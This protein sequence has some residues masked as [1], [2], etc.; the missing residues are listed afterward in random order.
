M[1]WGWD[2][3]WERRKKCEVQEVWGFFRAKSIA[4]PFQHRFPSRDWQAEFTSHPWPG[5]SPGLA[6]RIRNPFNIILCFVIGFYGYEPCQMSSV[7]LMGTEEFLGWLTD[8]GKMSRAD[9][10]SSASKNK[11]MQSPWKQKQLMDL[12]W[13]DSVWA[14]PR[15]RGRE[16]ERH[17]LGVGQLRG[18]S[19]SDS[20][21]FIFPRGILGLLY[22]MC[23]SHAPWDSWSCHESVSAEFLRHQGGTQFPRW[24]PIHRN[25][26]NAMDREPQNA[27]ASRLDEGKRLP[28]QRV[29]FWQFFTMQHLFFPPSKCI[30]P[31]LPSIHFPLFPPMLWEGCGFICPVHCFV[32]PDKSQGRFTFSFPGPQCLFACWFV[33]LSISN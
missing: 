1:S 8:R 6:P 24:C 7:S 22:P 19:Q 3:S 13:S 26:G 11:T 21:A 29:I 20:P 27:S 33:L 15:E 14:E 23:P 9:G 12:E 5:L 32:K 31:F 16:G 17:F 2:L 10:I 18:N 25:Q 28:L 30:S 4:Q